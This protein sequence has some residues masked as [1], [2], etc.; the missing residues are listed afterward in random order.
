MRKLMVSCLVGFT[1][2]SASP[3]ALSEQITIEN[4]PD[5]SGSMAL[6]VVSRE[7]GDPWHDG[8]RGASAYACGPKWESTNCSLVGLGGAWARAGT[9]FKNTSQIFP[10]LVLPSIELI[11]L[12]F[13]YRDGTP[14]RDVEV[15]QIQTADIFPCVIP[16]VVL[17]LK[18][19]LD[20]TGTYC[21][22]KPGIYSPIVKTSSENQRAYFTDS[23]GRILLVV[24]KERT[25]SDRGFN[26]TLAQKGFWGARSEYDFANAKANDRVVF[27]M[28]SPSVEAAKKAV[29]EAKINARKC[30]PQISGLPVN[31]I[32]ACSDFAP[33]P[34]GQSAIVANDPLTYRENTPN[35]VIALQGLTEKEVISVETMTTEF[36]DSP[37]ALSGFNWVDKSKVYLSVTTG[38]EGMC[39]LKV[40]T[41]LGTV[42]EVQMPVS[43]WSVSVMRPPSISGINLTNSGVLPAGKSIQLSKLSFNYSGSSFQVGLVA[44]L[45]FSI[46]NETVCSVD[47]NFRVLAKSA[48]ECVIELRWPEFAFGSRIYS[49]SWGAYVLFTVKSAAEIDQDAENLK[50]KMQAAA[51][52][53]R[54][55][56]KL[57]KP[58]DQSRLKNA[59]APMKASNNRSDVLRSKLGRVDYLISQVGKNGSIQLPPSEYADLLAGY[60]VLANSRQVPI[61]VYQAILQG[62]LLG[63]KKNYQS[64][65]AL[66]NLAYSKASAGCKKVI[67][68]P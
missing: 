63:E 52:K 41:T 39:R 56:A 1:L 43:S 33:L 61:F 13:T 29:A 48:G 3:F 54:Q 16:S 17:S 53:A 2:I 66:A 20:F 30:A 18:F 5:T 15:E 34:T 4:I 44:P 50:Y 23:E 49:S 46:K 21:D 7:E 37:K 11:P 8:V 64:A 35:S 47:E 28:D 6:A 10:S 36:C 65:F 9:T 31:Q 24:I 51:E 45:Y 67:G 25:Q 55:D 59:Y 14:A 26:V 57:C 12:Y 42:Y 32:P 22:W 19:N 62:A 58:S 38:S 40:K 27:D 60:P 68:K